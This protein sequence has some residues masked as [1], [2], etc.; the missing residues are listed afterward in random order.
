[1]KHSKFSQFSGFTLIELLAVIAITGVVG[2]MM[3]GILFSTLQGANKSESLGIIQQNGNFALGQIT[4]M[5]RY[6]TD[7]LDPT[8]C[9]TAPTPTPVQ[10]SSISIL[11]VDNN[12]TTF[13]CDLGAGTIASN[14]AALLDP[15]DVKVTACSFSCTQLTPY[16]Q[17]TM[18]VSFTLGKKN[19]NNLVENNSSQQFQTSI[20]LRNIR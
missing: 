4:K 17:P 19:S 13:S 16:D 5:V 18:T 2:S 1:M 8:T 12:I 11:N 9:Y 14:G 10:Q 20:T 6:S 3:F 15:N 7:I